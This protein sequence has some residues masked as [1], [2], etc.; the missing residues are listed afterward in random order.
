MGKSNRKNRAGKAAS[1]AASAPSAA[2][3]SSASNSLSVAASASTYPALN[4]GT[5]VES[6]SSSPGSHFTAP[7]SAYPA[8]KPSTSIE[9]VSSPVASPITALAAGTSTG[10]VSA[11]VQSF[12]PLSGDFTFG[13][14]PPANP[15]FT[16]P[17]LTSTAN[18]PT[19]ARVSFLEEQLRRANVKIAHLE[20]EKAESDRVR[21]QHESCLATQ[22]DQSMEI[23]KQKQHHEIS[24]K[25]YEQ[26]IKELDTQSKQFENLEHTVAVQEEILNKQKAHRESFEKTKNKLKAELEKSKKE[27]EDQAA[28]WRLE[29]CQYQARMEKAEKTNKETK[30]ALSASQELVERT[31]ELLAAAQTKTSK[32]EGENSS[33]KLQMQELSKKRKSLEKRV[34]EVE[35]DV[36]QH[37][38]DRA[39]QDE[40]IQ[41]LE[42]QLQS[43][44]NTGKHDQPLPARS[45]SGV[46]APG[47]S[48]CRFRG[49]QSVEAGALRS[50]ADF[51][52]RV[53]QWSQ[54]QSCSTDFR[55]FEHYLNG[56]RARGGSPGC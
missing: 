18:S 52:A 27:A 49:I 15:L 22:H 41:L 3:S 48:G 25:L 5:S 13:L 42:E 7:A 54:R 24:R 30:K 51:H 29:K 2:N 38:M 37:L 6:L 43:A 56:H 50:D 45:I 1:A 16:L 23:K 17:A 21:D 32:L 4:L 36:E 47:R 8:L 55:A 20:L 19:S 34:L 26:K 39:Q 46:G 11:S 9:I 44:L 40:K 10:I 53:G 12:T 31:Q 35:E 14:S 28:A 33:L